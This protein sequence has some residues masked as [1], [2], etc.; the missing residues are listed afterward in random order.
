MLKGGVPSAEGRR[1]AEIG[2]DVVDHHALRR[3]L[4]VIKPGELEVGG[5]RPQLDDG[6]RADLHV[7]ERMGAKVLDL[8]AIAGR[9]LV[10]HLRAD[11]KALLIWA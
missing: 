11:P 3:H 2:R 9:G 10:H 5:S 6:I 8:G 1:V 4:D 7:L